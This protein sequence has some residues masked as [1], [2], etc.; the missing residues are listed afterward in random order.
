MRLDQRSR[1]PP[2]YLFV[3]VVSE[4]VNIMSLV[5]STTV[6]EKI[7]RK[8]KTTGNVIKISNVK[9]NQINFRGKQAPT[10]ERSRAIEQLISGISTTLTSIKSEN[11]PHSMETDI[12][13]KY[14]A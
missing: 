14:Y 10:Y 12:V 3:P 9:V 6:L 7:P 13:R 5:S 11:S 4:G 1:V 2:N 8:F